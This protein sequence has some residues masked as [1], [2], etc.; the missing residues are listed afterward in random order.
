[1]TTLELTPVG[2]TRVLVA[3]AVPDLA[4]QCEL[5]TD[6]FEYPVPA[7]DMDFQDP[8]AVQTIARFLSADG[9][10]GFTVAV[11]PAYQEGTLTS[12]LEWLG[13]IQQMSLGGIA[14]LQVGSRTAASCLAAQEGPGGPVWLRLA[15][16]EDDRNLFLLSA[17]APAELFDAVGPV[18]TQMV[19]SFELV[20]ARG[21]TVAVS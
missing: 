21:Q 15:L 16:C 11:R 13:A 12:W 8:A 14:P 7:E 2:P 4:F 1:M 20:E 3:T 5:P 9:V 19:A 18:L 10:L 6:W 17:T